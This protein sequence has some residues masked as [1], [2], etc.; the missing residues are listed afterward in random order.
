[1]KNFVKSMD[2][3]K[4][5]FTHLQEK[6]SAISKA[7]LKEGIFIGPQIRQLFQDNIFNNLLEGREKRPWDTF[8]LVAT[9][10]LGN[11]KSRQFQVLVENLLEAYK[12]LGCNM[13]LKINFLHS[14]LDY[15]PL[16]CGAISNEHDEHLH[17][18]IL[19]MEQRYQG[20]WIPFLLADYCWTLLREAPLSICKKRT[21]KK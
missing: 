17:Q 21:K 16:N 11:D 5:A 2:K 20:R 10:F 7:K 15:F 8:K 4:K 3:T 14:H 12:S 1:M 6:F 13:S 19:T 9:N 18:I